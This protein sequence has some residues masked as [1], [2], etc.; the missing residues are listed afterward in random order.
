MMLLRK[1]GQKEAKKEKAYE[2]K[3]DQYGLPYEIYG[4]GFGLEDLNT[5]LKE[6][7]NQVNKNSKIENPD[8]DWEEVDD[9]GKVLNNSNQSDEIEVDGDDVLEVFIMENTKL[10]NSGSFKCKLCNDD[11]KISP[12]NIDVHFNKKHKEDYE[13]S[14]FA[15]EGTTFFL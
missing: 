9:N 12:M 13:K 5:L 3:Y 11:K 8:D 7:R 4:G 1:K 15:K 10:L 2:E 14:D 6:F